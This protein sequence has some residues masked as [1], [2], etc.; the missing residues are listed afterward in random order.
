MRDLQELRTRLLR[1]V[2]RAIADFAMVSDG[3]RIMVCLS[4]GK[5][6]Y[7]LLTLLRD[8]QG[9]APVEFELIAVNLDQK[10]PGF[11]REVLPDYLTEL[12]QPF[13][14]IEK[15]TYSIVRAKVP[16]G[17]TTCALCSRLRRGILYNT[18]VELGCNKIALGHHSD[19][20]LETFL[21]NLFFGGTLKSMPPVLRS[22]DRRN[23][24]IRPL[25]Y[26]READIARFAALM[27]YPIIPC[28]LCGSQENLK[29][30]RV[31]RLVQELQ[32]EIPAI[33]DSMLASLGHIVPSHLLD[34]RYFDFKGL[35]AQSGDV[36]AEL[37]AVFNH[38]HG[39]VPIA[40]G[41]K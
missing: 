1:G 2:G 36:R 15:D 32:E 3:D 19:D 12:G 31:K 4:G 9:R 7:T 39:F 35:S 14:I 22:N 6:S 17:E 34:T 27:K 41:Q 29:R 24:V 30:R 33:R 25:A 11:P 37:D 28:D 10:Q 5:D 38:Q 8:L 23:T 20:I 13:R 18:A 21:L 16:E 40:N 26:C